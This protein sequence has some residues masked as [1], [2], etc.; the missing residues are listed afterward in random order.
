M[1]LLL[2]TLN[3]KLQKS[4]KPRPWSKSCF[5]W[6]DEREEGGGVQLRRAWELTEGA[7]PVLSTTPLVTPPLTPPRSPG[8]FLPLSQ[9]PSILPSRSPLPLQPLIS[10][11]SCHHTHIPVTAWAWLMRPLLIMASGKEASALSLEP[12][13]T[14]LLQPGSVGG[15]SGSHTDRHVRQIW[16]QIIEL[17]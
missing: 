16:L 6:S 2:L 12:I 14:A 13:R 4:N 15:I 8:P 3:S 7:V 10:G 9:H 11:S 5:G 1:I 17:R